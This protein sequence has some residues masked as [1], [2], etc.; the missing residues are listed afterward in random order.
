MASLKQ[1]DHFV[2]LMLDNRSFD[3]L[4]GRLYP[5]GPD[6][7]G[8]SGQEENPDGQ[9]NL[10]RVWSDSAATEGLWLPTPDPGEHFADINEQLFGARAPNGEPAMNGFVTNYARQ[11]GSAAR[12]IMHGFQPEQL[13]AL[14][15]LAQAFAVCDH[16]FASAPCQTWPNRFFVH[17][18][19]AGGYE[20]NSPT[21]F[22]Y[23]MPTIFNALEG[24][25]P[26][27]WKIYF[28]DFPQA[29]TLSRLWGHLDRF[30][31]FDQFL[32][33]ARQGALPSYVF[34]EPRYFADQDW[35]NDMHPPHHIGYGDQL[36]AQVY[37]A[38]RNSPCWASTLLLITFDEHGG[39]YD[40]VPPPSAPPPEAP[41]QD[42]VFAFDRFGVR[43][44]T[45]VVSP[46]IK[47]G[48]VFRCD[49]Q[50]Y[51][52]TSVIKTLRRRFGIA[53]PLTQRDARAPDLEQVL[54]LTAPSNPGPRDIRPLPSLV[55]DDPA[56][57]DRARLAPL[58]DFQSAL[59]S[60]AAHL[61]PLTDATSVEA[62]IQAIIDG[63]MPSHPAATN[64][65]Q[66]M[67]LIQ[68]VASQLGR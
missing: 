67:P 9:G 10:I 11:T 60:A 23:L 26:E 50:P 30:A 8:L 21:H 12:D 5:A 38:L 29:L 34:I 42:Q 39:C 63:W 20:N 56:A 31:R 13:P 25:T 14:S 7:D 45:V 62:H 6:F 68:S 41:R 40:H 44:P 46:Y 48:T 43:V 58:N 1:I 18:G 37:Q 61:A 17:T 28:H 53:A 22:P 49:A 19:T 4:F 59:H 52:H 64:A 55:S 65:Q 57:L 35:P 33:D 32:A 36:V 3:N 15:A 24:N 16:W 51:D 27:G 66:A 47:P 2:V 54:S